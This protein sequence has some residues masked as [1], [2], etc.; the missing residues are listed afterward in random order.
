LSFGRPTVRSVCITIALVASGVGCG[1]IGYEEHDIV[2]NDSTAG[3]GGSNISD[4]AYERGSNIS[5]GAYE[6][7][8]NIS[9]GAYDVGADNGG[10]TEAS[11][12]AAVDVGRADAP[13]DAAD[14]GC[15]GDACVTCVNTA[16][17][18]CETYLNHVYRFCQATTA[19]PTWAQAE[20]D[21][22]V[23]QMRLVRIDDSMENAWLRSTG[24]SVLG[25]VEFWIGAEDP[26]TTSHWQWSDGAVFW[27]GGATPSGAPANGLYSNWVANGQR[28]T[29]TKTRTCAGLVN[30]TSFGNA[31]YDGQW[32][33][34]SCASLQPYVCERY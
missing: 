30:G 23:N 22:E 9:D 33:D 15:V 21:C 6:S 12:D 27:I 32:A 29:A 14:G 4:G 13:V 10:S 20:F 19:G 1:R 8:S 25:L 24:N 18:T 16:T 7:G 28:P 34:R 5:D 3:G 31:M 26:T 17:C 11:N 2:A